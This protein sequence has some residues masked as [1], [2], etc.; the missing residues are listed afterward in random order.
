LTDTTKYNSTDEAKAIQNE[1]NHS[2]SEGNVSATACNDLDS[3]TYT[4]YFLSTT[5]IL[6]KVSISMMKRTT[7]MKKNTIMMKTLMKMKNL[8]PITAT[9]I[10]METLQAKSAQQWRVETN[11]GVPLFSLL[12]L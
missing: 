12:F 6:T 1:S 5:T 3:H 8:T 9:S 10:L 2:S 11:L 7:Q 4:E